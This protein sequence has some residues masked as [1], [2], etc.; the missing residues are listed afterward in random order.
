MRFD[1]FA[2]CFFHLKVYS[3]A[4][5]FFLSPISLS[6]IGFGVEL[7]YNIVFLAAWRL[8]LCVGVL[9]LEPSASQQSIDIFDRCCYRK[10]LLCT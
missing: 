4:F 1:R 8:L 3:S 9:A 5:L 10:G 6:A 7:G 2:S